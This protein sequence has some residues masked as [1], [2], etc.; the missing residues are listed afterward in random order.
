M[1]TGLHATALEREAE[2]LLMLMLKGSVKYEEVGLSMF[3][4]VASYPGQGMTGPRGST[5]DES[6]L[7]SAYEN[8]GDIMITSDEP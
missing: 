2:C 5:H 6:F 7:G 3:Q 8:L 4:A 1:R